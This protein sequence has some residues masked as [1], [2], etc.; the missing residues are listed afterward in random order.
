[1]ADKIRKI[2]I[3]RIVDSPLDT[4]YDDEPSSMDMEIMNRMLQLSNPLS[5]DDNKKKDKKKKKKKDKKKK[6]KKKDKDKKDSGK[7]DIANLNIFDDEIGPDG[8]KKKKSKDDEDYYETRYSGSLVLLGNLLQEVNGDRALSRKYLKDM[9]TGRVKASPMAISTQMS[10]NSNL[11]ST[12]LSIIKEINTVNTKISDLE[13]K[14][15]ATDLRSGKGKESEQMNAKQVMDGLFDRLMNVDEL[16]TD[17]ENISKKMPSGKIPDDDIDID[18]RIRQLEAEGELE[19]NDSE[20]SFK[21]ERSK[22]DIAIEKNKNN[23]HWRFV[24]LDAD[25]DELFDYP[26]PNKRSVGGVTFDDQKMTA[27]DKLGNMYDVLLVNS[28]SVREDDLGGPGEDD[29]YNYFEDPDDVD[30]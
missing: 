24:A 15:V 14:K 25:G 30:E 11:L 9:M 20:K 16:P 7:L 12:K 8:E 5:K 13:L 2:K 28:F 23:G 19:F 29:D 3:S 4:D 22:V 6:G 1:M 10:N 17:F 27:K 18:E 26:L 21:Y